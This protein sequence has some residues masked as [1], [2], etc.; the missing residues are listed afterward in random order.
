MEE[1]GQLHVLVALT[2]RKDFPVVIGYEAEWAPEPVWTQ[3]NRHFI[4]TNELIFAK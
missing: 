1:S 2:A 4:H 3:D